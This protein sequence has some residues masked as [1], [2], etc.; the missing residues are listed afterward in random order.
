MSEFQKKFEKAVQEI[1]SELEA[2]DDATFRAQLVTHSEGNIAEI[3]EAFDLHI[4]TDLILAQIY[5]EFFV[6]PVSIPGK[7]VLSEG[8]KLDNPQSSD[9]RVPSECLIAA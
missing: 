6:Q 8:I 2:M 7:F 4:Q 5:H 1:A 9:A 3:V